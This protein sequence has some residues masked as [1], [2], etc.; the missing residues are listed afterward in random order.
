ML[1]T[2]HYLYCFRPRHRDSTYKRGMAGQECVAKIGDWGDGQTCGLW[3][4]QCVHTVVNWWL[5][6]VMISRSSL[7]LFTSWQVST[8]EC[9]DV[10]NSQ[11][12]ILCVYFLTNNPIVIR[13]IHDPA[14]R[15]LSR[16]TLVVMLNDD[17]LWWRSP[18]WRWAWSGS[19]SSAAACSSGTP[20]PERSQST[21]DNYQLRS[22]WG[23]GMERKEL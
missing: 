2:R 10:R 15:S 18:W 23:P 19:P 3:C 4:S 13:K 6:Y 17:C 7:C 21:H 22:V 5:V 8:N 11:S 20:R 16:P 14:Q 1:I 12:P 9:R